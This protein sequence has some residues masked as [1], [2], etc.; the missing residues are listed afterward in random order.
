M[1]S[2]QRT[3]SGRNGDAPHRSVR[4]PLSL[5]AVRIRTSSSALPVNPNSVPEFFK[6]FFDSDICAHTLLM[7]T[8]LFVT[9]ISPRYD[10]YRNFQF[11]S[12]KVV[13][14]IQTAIS[15][16]V[17]SYPVR[18]AQRLQIFWRHL[19]TG[20]CGIISIKLN[21]FASSGWKCY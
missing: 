8:Y 10:Q 18:P 3:T 21:G 17:P 11:A 12:C 13:P 15:H 2:F 7:Y 20:C 5:F 9:E 6:I 4:Q 19:R 16:S 14:Q 1:H